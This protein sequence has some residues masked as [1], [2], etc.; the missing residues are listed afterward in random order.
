MIEDEE[1]SSQNQFYPSKSHFGRSLRQLVLRLPKNQKPFIRS[2]IGSRKRASGRGG[3]V[4]E[5][6]V[7]FIRE[8]RFVVVAHLRAFF[9]D[10]H[11][12]DDVRTTV[13][14]EKEHQMTGVTSA[15]LLPLYSPLSP[16]SLLSL[17]SHR[18]LRSPCQKKLK[19]SLLSALGSSDSVL[20]T[21]CLH[22]TIRFESRSSSPQQNAKSLEGHQDMQE[23]SSRVVRVGTTNLRGIWQRK[24]GNVIRKW[25]KC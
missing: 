16:L 8:S 17:F 12:F 22:S 13:F 6:K 21:R 7:D 24:V 23:V 25:R 4:Q 5:E 2:A 14:S 1:S 3:N 9:V 11:S 10:Y 18:L 15:S 19:R 20:L